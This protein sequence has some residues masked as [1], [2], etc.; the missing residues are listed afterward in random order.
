MTTSSPD[1]CDNLIDRVV[2]AVPRLKFERRVHSTE[3]LD[4]FDLKYAD[5]HEVEI[6]CEP[7]R[8]SIN[9]DW[10]DGF[11]PPAYFTLV[12]QMV[13]V[14]MKEPEDVVRATAMKFKKQAFIEKDED[15]T[16]KSNGLS[17]ECISAGGGT[18]ITVDPPDKDRTRFAPPQSNAK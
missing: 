9:V 3:V 17:F 5:R 18:Q 10:P 6:V 11:P 13:S 14:A 12:S 15:A 4:T 16:I 1:E 7:H 8:L 2:T